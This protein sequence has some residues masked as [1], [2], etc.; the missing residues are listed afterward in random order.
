MSEAGQA[1]SAAARGTAQLLVARA[2]FMLS[3][4]VIS[5]VLA[6][7]LGP[8]EYGVYGVVMSILLWL[9]MVG[10]AG[11]PGALGRLLPQ[12]ADGGERMESTARGLLVIWA[13]L[14]FVPCWLAADLIAHLFHMPEAAWLLRLAFLDIPC[15]SL[16]IAYQGALGGRRLFGL[17]SVGFIVYSA[18]KL[19]G[20]FLLLALGLSVSGALLVNVLGT[21]GA[22]AFL[23]GKRPPASW[24]M[25]W[26][27]GKALLRV[28]VGMGVYL[29]LLQV[30]LSLD[31]WML[32]R[33][34]EGDH[35]VV[36]HYVAALNVARLPLIVP[37]VL[38]S[39]LFASISWALAAGDQSLAQRHLQAAGRFMLVLL[40]PACALAV[41]HAEEIMS[42]LYSQTYA[43]GGVYLAV[44]VVAFCLVAPLDAYLYALMA[45]DR[46]RFAVGILCALVPLAVLLNVLLIP[47]MG[48]VGAAVTLLLTMVAGTAA[49][50]IATARHYGA[51]LKPLSVMRVALGTAAVVF[52][53]GHLPG[54]GLWLVIE[55]AGLMG[56]YVALLA[57]LGELTRQDLHPFAVWRTSA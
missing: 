37:M 21:L 36:G 33:L 24:Q 52:L 41:T 18:T 50:M 8:T 23:I 35:Q 28:G 5:L 40:A 44:Q 13:M 14:L 53:G 54:G 38:T 9:Q 25:D 42:L 12:Q 51:L 34:W 1:T 3:G 11:M 43:A 10:T 29:I 20:I 31:L 2:W 32:Q 19:L 57:A 7:G 49:A 47:R 56:L 4:Y 22:L 39:V 55:L 6:R 30:L 46:R 26:G 48:P 45:A 17:L 27:V 15:N 16:Y